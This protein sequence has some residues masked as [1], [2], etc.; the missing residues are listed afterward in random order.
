MNGAAIHSEDGRA[1]VTTT[2]TTIATAR[3]PA[4]PRWNATRSRLWIDLASAAV[5]HSRRWRRVP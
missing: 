1:T 4:M 5:V 3:P 2:A